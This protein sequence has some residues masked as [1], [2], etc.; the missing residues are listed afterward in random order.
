MA[1]NARRAYPLA[2]VRYPNPRNLEIPGPNFGATGVA[3]PRAGKI[4]GVFRG[5]RG[6]EIVAYNLREPP[7]YSRWL[8]YFRNDGDLKDGET[9]ALEI[10]R[11]SPTGT[12]LACPCG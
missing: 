6:T 2:G 1:N 4:V 10:R 11:E 5:D 7:A 9:F 3:S 8:M 12:L